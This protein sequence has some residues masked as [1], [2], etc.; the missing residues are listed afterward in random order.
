MFTLFYTQLSCLFSPA[1][2]GRGISATRG[3]AAGDLLFVSHPISL[4]YGDGS[5]SY[6]TPATSEEDEAAHKAQQVHSKQCD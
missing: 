4:M 6:D 2:R 5:V 1:E 3:L